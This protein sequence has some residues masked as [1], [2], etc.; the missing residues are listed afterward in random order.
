MTA[1]IWKI[2]YVLCRYFLKASLSEPNEPYDC[3]VDIKSMS[4][5]MMLLAKAHTFKATKSA[6]ALAM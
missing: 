5:K 2:P 6:G 1:N 4:K 3:N